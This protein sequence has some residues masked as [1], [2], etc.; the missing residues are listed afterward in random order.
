MRHQILSRAFY[1]C[2]R[3]IYAYFSSLFLPIFTLGWLLHLF[4][5]GLAHCRNMATIRTHLNDLV[6]NKFDFSAIDAVDFEPIDRHKWNML[7][8]GCLDVKKIVMFCFDIQ[9]IKL[10]IVRLY[11]FNFPSRKI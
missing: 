3:N 5:S 10:K 2:K 7:R 9:I 4:Y 6:L 11:L 1:G 8:S